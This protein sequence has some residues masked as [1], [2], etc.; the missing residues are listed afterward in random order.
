[1]VRETDLRLSPTFAFFVY[2]YNCSCWWK[3]TL[4]NKEM[5]DSLVAANFP[6]ALTASQ[7]S[8]SK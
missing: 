3:P 7:T 4:S 1:M 2:H 5:P 8:S 6:L